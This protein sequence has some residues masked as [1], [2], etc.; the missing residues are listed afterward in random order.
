MSN[1]GSLVALASYPVLIEPHFSRSAQADVWSVGLG[2]FAVLA[3]G[4]GLRVWRRGGG[5]GTGT[6]AVASEAAPGVSS[7]RGWV[8]VWVWWFGLPACG[9]VLLLAVTNA[10]CQDLAVI[11]FLWVLPLSLYLLS[12]MIAFQGPRWYR[13]RV[14]LPVLTLAL[15]AVLW[16]AVGNDLDVPG[17]GLWRPVQWWLDQAGELSLYKAIALWLGAMFVA[18]VVCHGELYRRRPAPAELTR[19]YL[20][21]AGGG[22]FGGLAVAVI[23]PLLFRS[24][25]ELPL[26]LCAVTAVV[27]AVLWGDER[28]PL[29]RGRRPVAWV[30]VA[31]AAGALALGLG[32]DA[33]LKRRGAVSLTRSFYGVLKLVEYHADDPE[34]HEL[35]LV[36]GGTTH[37]LQFLSAHKRR[38]PTTYYTRTSGVGRALEQLSWKSAWPIGVVGLGAGTLAAWGRPGDYFRIYELNPEV[39]RLA[40]NR[41]SFLRDSAAR[42]EVVPGDARLSLERESAQLFDLLVLDAFSSDAIPV[43]LLTREA[44]EVYQRHLAPDGVIA[45]HISNL[46]LDL[47]PVMLRLAEHFDLGV[48]VV[49]DDADAEADDDGIGAARYGS[50]WVLMTQD[51]TFLNA[52]EIRAASGVPA[53]VSPKITLW[54]DEECPLLHILVVDGD[55][56]LEWLRRR[57]P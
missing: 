27:A 29:Y 28:S 17:H 48:A 54:T 40:T 20:L 44:F 23:A 13:R 4:C 26:G 1:A 25:L 15:G 57:L 3:L 39:A 31:L 11:P 50:D 10:M 5:D 56:W 47:E 8:W 46:Y 45:V 37:G 53:A 6:G 22:A 21:I 14:W 33:A 30:G 35:R 32:Y 16:A 55:S 34:A 7:G 49:H 12:Y 9:S 38:L 19:Y 51:R 42:I 36:H 52:P 43:H 18:C 24:Y 41:F 2:L